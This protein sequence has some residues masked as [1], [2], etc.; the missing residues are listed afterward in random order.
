MYHDV[1]DQNGNVAEG[2]T[3]RTE[4]GEGFVTWGIKEE[5]A[6]NLDFKGS[7]LLL[8]KFYLVFGNSPNKTG[9]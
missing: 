6:G 7:L 9:E 3:T 8:R 4:V 5:Q 2:R 1:N